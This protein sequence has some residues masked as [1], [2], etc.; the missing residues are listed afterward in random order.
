MLLLKARSND[1]ETT[2]SDRLS[3]EHHNLARENSNSMRDSGVYMV[4]E[5]PVNATALNVEPI[6][7]TVMTDIGQSGA[8]DGR[9]ALENHYTGCYL[10]NELSNRI[11]SVEQHQIP[12]QVL[13]RPTMIEYPSTPVTSTAEYYPQPTAILNRQQGPDIGF[14]EPQQLMATSSDFSGSFGNVV[15]PDNSIRSYRLDF[16]GPQTRSM[17]QCA[18]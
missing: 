18:P 15:N 1:N 16:V 14:T 6:Q 5:L 7:Q 10:S 8:W 17:A 11:E 4:E 2:R 12:S 9:H 13:A 3:V